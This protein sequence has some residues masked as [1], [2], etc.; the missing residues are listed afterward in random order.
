MQI[1]RNTNE[2]RFELHHDGAPIGSLQYSF[3]GDATVL[4]RIEV[5]QTYSGQGLAAHFTE[6]VL[7]QLG[8]AQEAVI[9][10]CPYVRGY[11][12]KNPQWRD[13]IP[14]DVELSA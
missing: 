14:P 7:G 8:Q 2:N 12:L 1:V 11:I 4:E 6:S 13:L 9:P 5:D 10:T 3:D